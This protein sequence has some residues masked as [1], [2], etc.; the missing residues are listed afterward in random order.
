MPGI[1][2]A[3]NAL[4]EYR[5]LLVD[6]KKQMLDLTDAV[7]V[8]DLTAGRTVDAMMNLRSTGGGGA[9]SD[10][11]WSRGAHGTRGSGGGRQTGASSGGGSPG[12]YYRPEANTGRYYKPSENTGR[13]YK[14]GANTGSYYKPGGAPISTQDDATVA[15]VNRLTDAVNRN[16]G[17]L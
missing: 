13:Y 12:R 11:P 14:P 1:S 4:R 3:T 8:L 16:G 6:A 5:D 2:A 10:D 7:E 15:A 17:L 9:A